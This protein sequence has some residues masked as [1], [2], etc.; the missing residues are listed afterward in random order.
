MDGPLSHDGTPCV[1]RPL[2]VAGAGI[3][4]HNTIDVD[5]FASL[6]DRISCLHC[7]VGSVSKTS[8]GRMNGRPTAT[9]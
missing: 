1:E 4:T 8:L 3:N 6:Q 7:H 2:G 9:R 5:G